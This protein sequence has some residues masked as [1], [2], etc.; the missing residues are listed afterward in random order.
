MT[1]ELRSAIA[2]TA[3]AIGLLAAGSASA[4]LAYVGSWEV[5][6]G[7]TWSAVQGNGQLAYT[8]QEAAALLFGGNSSN[9]V[10]STIDSNPADVNN[11]AWYSVIGYGGNQSNGGS[12]L[13]DNYSSKYLGLYYGPT[14]GYP[15]NDP[16]APASAYIND[17]ASGSTFTNFAFA[18]NGA[19]PEP[20]TWAVML[21]GVGMVGG[22]LRMNR[23]KAAPLTAA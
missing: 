14:S 15:T 22:G 9:Y 23:R 3:A 20:A 10:I 17:N 13:A 1:M 12:L 6:Q 19:V 8:G 5:D 18:V 4:G 21:L 11:M 7:P 2:G 16:T